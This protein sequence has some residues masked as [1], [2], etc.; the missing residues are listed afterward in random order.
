MAQM[1]VTLLSTLVQVI[2][3]VRITSNIG[4]D[5]SGVPFT[6]I[7]NINLGSGDDIVYVGY[8]YQTDTFDAKVCL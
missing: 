1:V 2:H 6:N 5:V 4:G 7:D 8:R 3:E